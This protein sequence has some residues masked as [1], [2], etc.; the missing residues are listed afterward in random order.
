MQPYEPVEVQLLTLQFRLLRAARAFKDPEL[1]SGKMTPPDTY[2]VLEKDVCLSRAYAKEDV[3]RFT[4]RSPGQAV[5][6]FYGYSRLLRPRKEVEA[7]FCP[8]FNALKFH[9]LI[10]QQGLLS[11]D[12]VHKAIMESFVPSQL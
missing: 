10:L 2:N 12:L 8:K 9:D 5:S 11:P 7:A 1:Q 6:Y 3:E 4:Y